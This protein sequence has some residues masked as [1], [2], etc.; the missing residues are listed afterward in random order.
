MPKKSKELKYESI[1]R[2]S[3]WNLCQQ[4]AKLL[5]KSNRSNDDIELEVE[6]LESDIINSQI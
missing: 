4:V 5:Y 2:V 3:R 1:E 6:E